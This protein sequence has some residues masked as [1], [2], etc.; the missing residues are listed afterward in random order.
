MGIVLWRE[1]L[2]AARR[3]G[4]WRLRWAGP[5]C[6]AAVLVWARLSLRPPFTG[7]E[8]LALFTLMAK[9]SLVFAWCVLPW[10]T[11]DAIASERR[12]GTLGLLWLTPLTPGGVLMAK[13]LAH[14]IRATWLLASMVPVIVFPVLLGGVGWPDVAR[15][16]FAWTAMAGLSMASGL[17]ASALGTGWWAVRLLA[18]AGNVM[19]LLMLAGAWELANALAGSW[20]PGASPTPTEAMARLA[21]SLRV[22]AVMWNQLQVGSLPIA[23][24]ATWATAGR[25]AVVAV[26][27]LGISAGAAAM[28]ART[29]RRPMASPSGPVK[30]RRR[31]WRME[32]GLVA[33]T[34][35]GCAALLGVAVLDWPSPDGVRDALPI[36]G[37]FVQGMAAVAGA[38]AVRDMG[39]TPMAEMV[40]VTPLGLDGWS[41]R[42]LGRLEAGL[43]IA[44]G[45]AWMATSIALVAAMR[46][47]ERWPW[48]LAPRMFL[49]AMTATACG[50]GT[51][52]LAAA[53]AWGRRPWIGV[54]AGLTWAWVGVPAMT[55]ASQVAIDALPRAYPGGWNES[56]ASAH[57]AWRRPRV[58]T[59]VVSGILVTSIMVCQAAWIRG[60]LGRRGQAPRCPE[61][62]AILSGGA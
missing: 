50:W 46:G 32:D 31:R 5:L 35:L 39:G 42:V 13:T 38:T 49:D 52:W 14:G 9:A 3:P 8:G 23:M 53:A 26:V 45:L 12:E 41:R 34:A 61:P 57:A 60:R 37:W 7:D 11:A 21:T 28:A 27:M 44:W 59:V 36:V 1:M 10:T 33:T 30:A 19:V 55:L 56:W 22:K 54:V 17:V 51:F 29:L 40:A 25:M 15:W 58:G 48:W 4:T 6:L 16:A 62:G 20:G 2:E 43:G 47:G 18:L 24:P